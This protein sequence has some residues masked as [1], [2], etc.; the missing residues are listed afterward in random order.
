M[1]ELTTKKMN[2][3]G[4]PIAILSLMIGYAILTVGVPIIESISLAAGGFV[5]LY[6]LFGI[7]GLKVGFKKPK[8]RNTNFSI[9]LCLC[10][11][12]K[13]G[14]GICCKKYLT[15]IDCSE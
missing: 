15:R 1:K 10:G 4:I 9:F 8:K 3:I 6:S 14:N 12:F 2:N 11:C 5:G 7:E 13:F